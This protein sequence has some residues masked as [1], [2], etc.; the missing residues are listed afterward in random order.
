MIDQL[1]NIQL[2][3]AQLAQRATAASVE[4]QSAAQFVA[5]PMAMMAELAEEIGFLAADKLQEEVDELEEEEKYQ[6]FREVVAAK[7][8]E[9]AEDNLANHQEI[10]Q[11]LLGLLRHQGAL[12][13]EGFFSALG[14]MSGGS[15][16]AMLSV[17]DAF[18][19]IPE[20]RDLV[21]HLGDLK[22]Q[23]VADNEDRLLASMNVSAALSERDPRVATDEAERILFQYEDAVVASS[24]VLQV[25]QRLGTLEGQEKITDWR[26]FLTESVA[27]DLK[28][29]PSSTDKEKL[30][31][32]LVELQ[33]FRVF[34]T[35]A[36]GLDQLQDKYLAPAGKD[37]SSGSLMQQTLDYVEQPIREYPKV[38]S[39]GLQLPG[40][41]PVLFLQDFRALLKSLPDF[42]YANE[43]QKAQ[44]LV[45]LQ[46]K[47]DD[48][49]YSEFDE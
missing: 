31:I 10:A 21:S 35:L 36:S 14:S 27:A 17:L 46:Q 8:L 25:F 49:T 37:L 43:Q 16:N 3:A 20:A 48:L 45:P 24:S 2:N 9:F 41:Q 22:Q 12:D 44:L 47:I 42:A 19:D 38:E 40:D 23:F 11:K 39:I 28:G 26:S 5:D 15:A 29:H 4:N 18:L 1:S 34:N 32:L 6:G 13:R 30:Q 7:N 33:G